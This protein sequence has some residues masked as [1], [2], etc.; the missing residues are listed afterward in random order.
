MQSMLLDTAFYI[1]AEILIYAGAIKIVF[2]GCCLAWPGWQ[3]APQIGPQLE[4]LT[5]TNDSVH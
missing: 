1:S 2:F 3:D 5:N 4:N